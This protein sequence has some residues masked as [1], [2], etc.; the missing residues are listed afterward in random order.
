MNNYTRLDIT[1]TMRQLTLLDIPEKGVSIRIMDKIGSD[2]HTLG[3]YLLNDDDGGTM[4]EITH[5]HKLT[6]EILNEIF[7]R[8]INGQGQKDGK[9]TNTWKALIKY[10]KHSKFMALADEIETVLHFCTNMTL[11]MDHEECQDQMILK[12]TKRLLQ[13]LA[14]A[15]VAVIAGAAIIII[16]YCRRCKHNAMLCYK[17][18]HNNRLEHCTVTVLKHLL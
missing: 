10:L 18:D 7:H 12:E 9:K 13:K 6:K 1:P 16:L 11:H 5:D 2:Y 4:K 8:W 15:L 14:P 3:T 17:Y